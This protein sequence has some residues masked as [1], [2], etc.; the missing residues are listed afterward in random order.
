[1]SALFFDLDGTL[2]D[3]APGIVRCV[4]FGLTAVGCEESPEA[5][6]RALIGTPLS[7]IYEAL[8]PGCD[9]AF[10][11]RA[12]AAYRQRFDDVGMFENS[13]FPGVIEA[14]QAFRGHG[15]SLTVV[16]SKVAVAAQRV[17][18]HFEIAEFFAAVHGPGL[19][20][21]TSQKSELLGRALAAAA[22]PRPRMAMFG[23]RKEDMAAAAHHGIRGIG[24]AWGYGAA[25]ELNQATLVARTW[26]DAVACVLS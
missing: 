25:G 8:V 15:Y 12:V 5:Q 20:R 18:E 19:D 13:L 14:L 7:A 11:D 23:D 16:T 10:V 9:E 2:T 4:N 1:V 21:R 17:I 24:A 26:P 3:S 6:I 22:G